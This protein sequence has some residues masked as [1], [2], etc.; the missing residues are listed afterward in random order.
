MEHSNFK[1]YI[2]PLIGNKFFLAAMVFLVYITVFDQNSL[3]DRYSLA[4]RINQLEKQKQHYINEIEQNNRKMEELQSSIDNLEKFAREEYLMKKKEE[5][6]FVVE[7][8]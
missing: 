8:E 4:R 1:K 3:F 2:K 5:V 6:I 7:E